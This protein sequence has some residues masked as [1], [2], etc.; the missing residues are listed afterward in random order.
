MCLTFS[1]VRILPQDQH[2][3]FR[4]R[5]QVKCSE[6]FLLRWED[7]TSFTFLLN[8]TLKLRPI[9][10]GKLLSQQG[11]PIG[12]HKVSLR[13]LF[14]CPFTHFYACA[15]SRAVIVKVDPFSGLLALHVPRINTMN[16][17]RCLIE[18]Q[19]IR[20]VSKVASGPRCITINQRATRQKTLCQRWRILFIH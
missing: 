8:K 17:A 4:K 12:F 15:N 18:A 16:N 10:F 5:R 13:E 11:V 7:L 2:F 14:R 9:R 3:H 19:V 1:V 20:K 6:D